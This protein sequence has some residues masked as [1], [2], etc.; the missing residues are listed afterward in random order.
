[1]NL[2]T[3][4][5]HD[6]GLNTQEFALLCGVKSTNV[7]LQELAVVDRADMA[8]VSYFLLD[9]DKGNVRLLLE[10]QIKKAEEEHDHTMLAALGRIAQKL[11]ERKVI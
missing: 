2:A 4:V 1:M 8:H 11:T 9:K 6:L 10:H 7:T 3:K 5:R